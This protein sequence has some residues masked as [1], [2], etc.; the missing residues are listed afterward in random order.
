MR[1][2]E[3]SSELDVPAINH[4]ETTPLL[5]TVVG[6]PET[7]TSKSETTHPRASYILSIVCI[8]LVLVEFGGDLNV[9]PQNQI[10]ES[11]IC[12]DFY[13]HGARE[14]SLVHR[15]CKVE[16]IQRELALVNGWKDMFDHIPSM[17]TSK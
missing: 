4:E 10:F 5:P 14:G 8:M 11:I 7:P 16:P 15:D 17:S 6:T 13:G 1:P 2:M 9:A 3:P 12:N